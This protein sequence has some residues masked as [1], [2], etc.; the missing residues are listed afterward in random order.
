METFKNIILGLLIGLVISM[1]YQI[2]TLKQPVHTAVEC[3]NVDSDPI[4]V[5]DRFFDMV[6]ELEARKN[7]NRINE[8]EAGN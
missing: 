7:E 8:P 6:L 5:F 3:E 1:G 4:E 2:Y